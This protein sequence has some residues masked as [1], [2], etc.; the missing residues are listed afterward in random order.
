MR[1]DNLMDELEHLGTAQNRKVYARHG[2]SPPLFGVSYAALD[3]LKKRIKTDHGIAVAL[4][5]T[6]NH[7]ARVLACMI[8]DP[9]ALTTAQCNRWVKDLDNYVLT[10]A[11]AG[12]VARS[13]LA[14]GR[15]KLW[16][17]SRQEWTSSAGWGILSGMVLSDG[18]RPD[19][20]YAP[21]LETIVTTIHEAPNRTRH[22]MNNALIAI[23]VRSEGLAKAAITAARAMGTLSVDHGETNC[24]TPDAVAY[25]EKTRAHYAAKGTPKKR[26]RC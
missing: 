20:Y 23:G 10:D 15:M 21:Y 18:A 14:E 1:D 22:A 5:D 3:V 17:R 19:S 26:K 2:V 16:I 6:G 11:L 25:I 9:T 7:D 4:W 24:K 13:P 8:A 12:L